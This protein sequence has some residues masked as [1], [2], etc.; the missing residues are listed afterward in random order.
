[1]DH[2]YWLKQE[3]EP[4]FPEILWS[5]PETKHGAGKLAIIGGNSHGFGAPGLAYT[6]GDAAGAGVIR[7]MLPDAVRK[8]VGALLPDAD[9]APSN[10][11]GSFAR[12]ALAELLALAGWSDTALLAGDFGRNSETAILLESFV[13]KYTGLLTVTQDAIDYFKETPLELVDREQ[14]LIV[15]SLAQL[16]KYFINTPTIMPITT[17]M[18]TLQ[19][20]EA[21]HT[22]TSE[23]PAGIITQ[24]NDLIFVAHSG[25]VCTMK[26]NEKI[27]RVATSARASVFWLQNPNKPFEAIVSSLVQP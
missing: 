25:Q 18:T 2:T 19:L 22:Y 4:L 17:T 3:N 23:H 16:Q 11:S 6:T 10:P 13:Q 24:H 21:L 7:V 27:W 14:T 5:R 26:H 8:V 20:V 15:L 9:F 12:N 1:M